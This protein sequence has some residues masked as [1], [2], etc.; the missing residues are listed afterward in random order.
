M[1]HPVVLGSGKRLFRDGSEMKVLR[2]VDSRLFGSGIVVLYYQPAVKEEKKKQYNRGIGF[3][4]RVY[5]RMEAVRR[6]I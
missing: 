4:E 2:L 5:I 3:R 1:I 6:R